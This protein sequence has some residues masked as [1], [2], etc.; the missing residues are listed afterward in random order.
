MNQGPVLT[1]S[2]VPAEALAAECEKTKKMRLVPVVLTE[3]LSGTPVTWLLRADG[4]KQLLG[5]QS[6][7]RRALCRT[8]RLA[9][10]AHAIFLTHAG[11]KLMVSSRLR[12]SDLRDRH[13]TD[14]CLRL[15]ICQESTFG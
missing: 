5:Y 2:I 7:I 4:R 12:I 6:T 3:T 11:S 8:G 15:C 14:G 10:E 13:A 9:S 1:F